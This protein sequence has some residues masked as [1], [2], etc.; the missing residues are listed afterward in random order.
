MSAHAS[1]ASDGLVVRGDYG[2]TD[3]RT[4]THVERLMR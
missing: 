4:W 1:H 3:G 2:S